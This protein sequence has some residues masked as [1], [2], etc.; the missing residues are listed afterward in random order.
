[1]KSLQTIQTLSKIGK[2]ISKLVYICCMV[3]FIACAVGIVAI[4]IGG[5]ALVFD[6]ASLNDVLSSEAVSKGTALATLVAGLI[7]C[8]GEYVVA[9][10]AY[11]YFDNELNTGTPF[12]FEG[13][14]ELMRLGIFVIGINIVSAV[15][16]QVAQGIISVMMENVEALT[17][18]GGDSVAIG[19]MLIVMSLFCRYGAELIANQT[20]KEQ[21]S[22]EHN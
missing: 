18:E 14:K 10:M 9:R 12:T 15:L 20:T 22:D 3:G 13:S 7:L 6:D 2:I 5:N 1:M 11:R 4:A 17:L 8:T 19:V 21:N 16:A